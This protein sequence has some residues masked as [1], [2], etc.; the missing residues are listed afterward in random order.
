MTEEQE[1]RLSCRR[2]LAMH[3]FADILGIFL[4]KPVVG[5]RIA[6]DRIESMRR[7]LLHHGFLPNGTQLAKEHGVVVKTAHRDVKFISRRLPLSFNTAR[8]RY[9]LKGRFE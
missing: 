8:N 7:R 2:A 3:Q 4:R 9:E 5:T 1:I 6:G